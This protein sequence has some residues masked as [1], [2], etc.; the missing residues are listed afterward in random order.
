MDRCLKD[1]DRC[2]ENV[3]RGLKNVDRCL[4]NVDR[5][6]DNVGVAIVIMGIGKF[7]ERFVVGR[8]HVD[9][10]KQLKLAACQR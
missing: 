5:Y 9:F 1:V 2:L 8:Q 10:V 6:L 3:G 7:S 4:K